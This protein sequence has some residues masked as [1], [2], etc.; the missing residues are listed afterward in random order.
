MRHVLPKLIACWL[1]VCC[2]SCAIAQKVDPLSK[3]TMAVKQKAESLSLKAHI[4]VIRLN[5]PKEFGDFLSCDQQSLTFYDVDS[6]TN[7]T[8]EYAKIK[9]IKD[10]YHYNF[11]RGKHT[12]P[13]RTI[14]VL[15]I[16]IGVFLGAI[17][18]LVAT[19][20]D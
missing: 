17:I 7:V 12:D 6:R 13:P 9:K 2:I 15:P 19:Q 20:M 14:I 5:A 4:T 8:L 16:V 10:G 1:I 18:G 3:Q 11:L